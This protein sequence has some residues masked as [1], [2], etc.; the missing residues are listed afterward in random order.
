MGN[1]EIG[2][3][4]KDLRTS[5]GMTLEELSQS[6]HVSR[7]TIHRYE[8]GVISNIPSDK[9]ELIAKALETTPS[10]LMGWGD[11]VEKTNLKEPVSGNEWRTLAQLHLKMCDSLEKQGIKREVPTNKFFQYIKE[12]TTHE[13][14]IKLE[15]IYPLYMDWISTGCDRLNDF[16]EADRGY[17]FIEAAASKTW[18]DILD[19]LKELNAEGQELLL[20][21][22]TMLSKN[23]KYKKKHEEHKAENENT[24]KVAETPIDYEA[25]HQKKTKGKYRR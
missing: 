9:I 18:R 22:A 17:Y 23:E 25:E 15:P 7:Q 3:R 4:I 12:N 13:Q 2:K 24:Q 21:Y 20:E 10:Y 14:L 5:K 16:V 11:V 8:T 19:E 6:V 1:S